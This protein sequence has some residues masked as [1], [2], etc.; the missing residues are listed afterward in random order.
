[1]TFFVEKMREAFAA[2]QI[3]STKNIGIFE[4]L[5]LEILMDVVKDVVSFEQPGPVLYMNIPNTTF[6]SR[7]ILFFMV[8][9]KFFPNI[10]I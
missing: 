4:I 1:M 9:H 10:Y 2:S 8:A 7:H 6:L 3:F 5:T